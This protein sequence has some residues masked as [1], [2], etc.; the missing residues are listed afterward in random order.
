MVQFNAK[1]KMLKK[2]KYIKYH[3]KEVSKRPFQAKKLL[4]ATNSGSQFTSKT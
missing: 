2:A 1:N 4:Y 3:S